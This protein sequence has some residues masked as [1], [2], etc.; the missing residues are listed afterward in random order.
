MTGF[1]AARPFPGVFVV[2]E[3]VDGSGSTTATRLLGAALRERGLTTLETCEPSDGPIG[4]LI[5]Q[6]LQHKVPSPSGSGPRSFDWTTLALLFAADRR[7][8]LD[9]KV[10]PAL[11]AGSVVISD[12]YYLSSLAYQS[13]TAPG[14]REVVPWIRELNAKALRPD[15][16]V[17]ID[18]PAAVAEERRR[19]RGGPEE[20]FEKREL[21]QKLCDVYRSA[22]ELVPHDPLAVVSGVGAPEE[23]AAQLLE[24]V[25]AVDPAFFARR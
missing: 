18:V 14:G 19:S 9:Q 11:Q 4:A 13:V 8:H 24:A 22:H 21:Q 15:L 5:R 3:G 20:L 7:D 1:Q 16:T 6:V 12:R 10:I 17:V 23:V 2:L 25:S